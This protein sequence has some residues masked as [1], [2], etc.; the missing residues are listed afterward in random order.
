[1]KTLTIEAQVLSATHQ[2][3]H[4]FSSHSLNLKLF[5]SQKK[6]AIKFYFFFES[7]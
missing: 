1:M 2:E 4:L 7:I 6:H 5:N 3:R